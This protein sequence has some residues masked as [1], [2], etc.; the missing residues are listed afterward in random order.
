MR[1]TH[2]TGIEAV[3]AIAELLGPIPV[4]YVTG[5]VGMLAELAA[6]AVVEKPIRQ[7]LFRAACR[8]VEAHS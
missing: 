6:P 4:V 1:I 5:N 7:Q 3:Q 8:R 2:G